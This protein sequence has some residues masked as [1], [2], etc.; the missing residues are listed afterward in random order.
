MIARRT[1]SFLRTLLLLSLPLFG[2]C[3]MLL[4]STIIEPTVENLRMQTDLDLAC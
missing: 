4:T 3:S 1:S 2:S